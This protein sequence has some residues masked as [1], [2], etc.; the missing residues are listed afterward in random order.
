M[1]QSR[2]VVITIENHVGFTED[3]AAALAKAITPEL[4]EQITRIGGR[5]VQITIESH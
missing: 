4:R 5:I 3:E 2:K 1:S